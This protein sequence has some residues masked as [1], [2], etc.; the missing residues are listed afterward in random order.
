VDAEQEVV[1]AEEREAFSHA[2]P[3][4]RRHGQWT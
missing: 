4:L 1:D 3:E 2:G